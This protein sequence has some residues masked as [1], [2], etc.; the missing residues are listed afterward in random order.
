MHICI[1]P[2]VFLINNRITG[3]SLAVQCL[4]FCGTGLI[5]GKRTKIPHA[6]RGGQKE[7][8]KIEQRKETIILRSHQIHSLIC[9]IDIGLFQYLNC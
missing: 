1:I 2:C 3:N 9:L 5:P 8:K 6:V 4:G 7:K